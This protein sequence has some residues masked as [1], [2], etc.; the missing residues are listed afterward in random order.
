MSCSNPLKLYETDLKKSARINHS[1][2][3]KSALMKSNNEFDYQLIPCRYCLN[4]RIDRQNEMIDKCEYE[5]ISKKCGAFVTFTYD[6]IHL[7]QNSFIDSK[8]GKTVAT[9]NKKDGKDFLNRLNKLVHKESDRLKKLGLPD[10]LCNKDYTYV[11]TH[12]YGDKFNRPHFHCLFFGLD[13][14]YCERL[15]WRAWN[16]HG[17][18]QVGAIKNGGIAYAV[19]YID[20]QEYGTPAFF[21]YDYHHLV[22]PNSSHSLGLGEGLYLSQ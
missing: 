3:T 4:C 21:K 9:I 22:R 18:I 19:K 16:N 2:F 1:D 14:A 12:E 10:T 7:F 13:F 20:S 8:T 11:I 5:Y 6:D 17:S 15:F